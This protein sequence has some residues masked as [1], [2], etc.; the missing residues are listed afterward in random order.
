[1]RASRISS[2][3]RRIWDS[4]KHLASMPESKVIWA[5]ERP[6]SER[7][8]VHDTEETKNRMSAPL[9]NVIFLP[10]GL[11]F[12]TILLSGCDARMPQETNPDVVMASSDQPPLAN[13]CTESERTEYVLAKLDRF[14]EH[15]DDL[16]GR[17]DLRCEIRLSLN[18]EG[19]VLA[20]EFQECPDDAK[21]RELVLSALERAQP[22]PE[23]SNPRCFNE[24][25]YISVGPPRA[26]D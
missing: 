3:S 25:F 1:M 5:C 11:I 22:L 16:G 24:T 2:R 21:L 23:P 26:S 7:A 18:R 14:S 10:L 15:W 8:I 12:I 6:L 19:E 4:V 17:S 13:A 20:T 9:M